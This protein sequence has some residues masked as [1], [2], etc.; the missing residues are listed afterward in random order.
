MGKYIEEA[1]KAG[2]LISTEG[3]QPSAKGA[4][5]RLTGGKFAVTDGPFTEAKEI[6][7]G[8]ALFDVP[9]RDE[10]LEWVKRFMKIVG[11]GEVEIRLLHDAPAHAYQK[12]RRSQ[13]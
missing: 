5:V 4:R 8:F 1:F 3:C 9:S 2:V 13:E 12:Q 11:D 6:V 10:L 7:G